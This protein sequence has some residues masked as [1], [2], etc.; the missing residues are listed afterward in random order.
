MKFLGFD[1][2]AEHWS[3]GDASL[4][5]ATLERA[6]DGRFVLTFVD[7]LGH[8]HEQVC[9]RADFLDEFGAQARTRETEAA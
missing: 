3:G 7:E 9:F 4:M 8:I 5:E 6:D 2:G 1:P